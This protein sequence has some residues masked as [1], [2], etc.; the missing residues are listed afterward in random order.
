MFPPLNTFQT[1]TLFKQLVPSS[2]LFY[3]KA[4]IL[5]ISQRHVFVLGAGERSQPIKKAHPFLFILSIMLSQ[6]C[7]LVI[8]MATLSL[9]LSLTYEQHY[10]LPLIKIA[11]LFE[12][13]IICRNGILQNVL[14]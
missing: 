12:N 13:R 7:D 5:F 9:A 2:N 1:F 4:R 8:H 10:Y 11:T 6:P 3:V 14:K